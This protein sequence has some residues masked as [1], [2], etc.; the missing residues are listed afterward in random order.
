MPFFFDERRE[1]AFLHASTTTFLFTVFSFLFKS[2]FTR[3][4]TSSSFIARA[5][6]R[7]FG[8]QS[9]QS[10]PRYEVP[11]IVNSAPNRSPSDRQELYD[12]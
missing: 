9:M 8:E 1:T 10:L 12:C 7:A 2:R 6:G 3:S 4:T 5:I 11:R